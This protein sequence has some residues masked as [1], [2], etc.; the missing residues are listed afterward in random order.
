MFAIYSVSAI[1]AFNEK[2][3][4]NTTLSL[5][6]QSFLLQE[7]RLSE[8]MWTQNYRSIYLRIKSFY[9][10]FNTGQEKF[11]LFL[12]N[13]NSK[14]VYF[15]NESYSTD[16]GCPETPE[17]NYK[18]AFKD[19]NLYS[20]VNKSQKAF[21]FALNLKIDDVS[22]GYLVMRLKG[23]D[24]YFSG[25]SFESQAKVMIPIVLIILC[26]Y[27]L[28]LIV[29]RRLL[30]TP[31][32]DE[33]VE[34][35]NSEKEGQVYRQI[36]HD[37]RSPVEVLLNL[38][39]NFKGKL[40]EQEYVLFSKSLNIIHDL[41]NNMKTKN[42]MQEDKEVSLCLS[43]L[44]DNT[45]SLKRAEYIGKENISL[46]YDFTNSDYG[47]FV[48]FNALTLNRIL[49]NLINNS[50]EAS[51]NEPCRIILTTKRVGSNCVI[52]VKDDGKGISPNDISNIFM[53]GFTTKENNQ[54]LGLHHAKTEIE[55]KGGKLEI[56]SEL[57]QYTEITITLPFSGQP[58]W[59]VDKI[60]ISGLKS[61]VV[62]D[63]YPLIFDLWR[64]RFIG[65]DIELIYLKSRTELKNFLQSNQKE[66]RLFLVDY[67]FKGSPY[68]GID[69][70][71][72]F[73][74]S[75]L[76]IL[77]TSKFDSPEIVEASLKRGSKLISKNVARNIEVIS[78][79]SKS[80]PELVLI[81]DDEL[82]RLSW[83]F[84]AKNLSLKVHVFETVEDFLLN[85]ELFGKEISIYI[86]SHLG[87]QQKGEFRSKE[88]FELGFKN[89]Y[90]ATGESSEDIPMADYPWLSGIQGKAFPISPQN[91]SLQ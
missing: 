7:N 17:I 73:E 71:D 76:C 28:W 11:D 62:V 25:Y 75:N 44:L 56:H 27:G 8:E 81:D 41:S 24:S 16:N 64:S 86:D 31:Y 72:E 45:V 74:L 32:I 90:L 12:L 67:D 78:D 65:H 80:R 79:D 49:S 66:E 20:H 10:K 13:E 55:K 4:A 46:H 68:N 19:K 88:L 5:I 18:D 22:S 42:L 85:S 48:Q 2:G 36:A 39:G 3:R 61:I 51:A 33:L 38:A 89:I 43:D 84:A 63:D 83:K 1:H 50:V 91:N 70:I 34:L 53:K 30:I 82:V 87:N 6:K 58:S 23:H 59:Y 29:A 60:N 15:G 77:V 47:T 40:D 54:G 26:F 37:L 21:V 52:S 57:G 9:K 14:C 69:L 35:N